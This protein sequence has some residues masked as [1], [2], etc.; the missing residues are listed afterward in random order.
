MKKKIPR[1]PMRLLPHQKAA[2][3]AA[4]K[5]FKTA[6]RGRIVHACGTGKTL[7]ALHILLK[8]KAHLAIVLVPS[9]DLLRQ[10]R[11]KWLKQLRDSGVPYHHQVVSSSIGG[12]TTKVAEVR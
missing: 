8:L 5:H 7:V 9:L 11:K 2:V 4:V 3:N 10:T 12:A 6:T 1:K